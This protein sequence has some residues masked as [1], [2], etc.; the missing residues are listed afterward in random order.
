MLQARAKS[1]TLLFGAGIAGVVGTVVLASRA[2]LKL[3]RMTDDWQK[4]KQEL[5]EH[6]VDKRDMV[7]FYVRSAKELAVLYAPAVALGS[8]SIAALTGSHVVL[9]K[10]NVAI[11]AAYA[12]LEQTFKDYRD[13]IEEQYGEE[14]DL[15]ARYGSERVDNTKKGEVAVRAPRTLVNP[16]YARFFDETCPSWNR[17]QDYNMIFLEMQQTYWNNR[18]HANGHVFL[19]EVYDSLGFERTKA[20]QIMGWIIT[21]DGSTDGHIDFGLFD[22]DRERARAFVNGHESAILLDFNVTNIYDKL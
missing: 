13:R 5:E 7:F 11:T 21:K 16:L 14:A 8:A 2:T 6:N 22:G 17:R 10:R 18:L 9:T 4:E 1:P 3:D 12:G 19:N 20:G 15:A